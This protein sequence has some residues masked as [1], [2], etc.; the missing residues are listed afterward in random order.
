MGVVNWVLMIF[1]WHR[2]QCAVPT[3]VS[4]GA[5]PFVGHQLILSN[6][7][8]VA[9]GVSTLFCGEGTAEASLFRATAVLPLVARSAAAKSLRALPPDVEELVGTLRITKART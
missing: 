7:S 9:I 2:A 1:A 3:K 4:S 5:V 6:R 8:S